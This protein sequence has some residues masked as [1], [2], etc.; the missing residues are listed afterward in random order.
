LGRRGFFPIASSPASEPGPHC[1]SGTGHLNLTTTTVVDALGRPVKGTDP[2]GNVT[3]TVYND[4]NHEVQVYPGWT[5]TTTTGPTQVTREDRTHDPSYTE[6]FT[7]SAT[8][9][10]TNGVPDGTEAYG[11]LQSLSR[12]IT[13]KGGQ[14]LEQDNYFN[15]GGVPYGTNIYLG[16]AGVNYGFFR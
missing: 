6:A 16:T 15:M 8:P 14:V 12:T 5:G 1:D 7:M 10:L 13:S 9:H 3:Y 2:N 11:F 4:A